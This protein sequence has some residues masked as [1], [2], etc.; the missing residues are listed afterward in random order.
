MEDLRDAKTI[1]S[2]AFPPSHDAV[3]NAAAHSRR[4]MAAQGLVPTLTSCL[5]ELSSLLLRHGVLARPGLL[6]FIEIGESG[7]RPQPST[8]C[9]PTIH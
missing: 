9:S 2:M 3:D 8:S 5:Q 1:L 7:S 4:E 6:K